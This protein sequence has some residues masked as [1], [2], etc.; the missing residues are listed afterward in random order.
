MNNMKILSVIISIC[1]CLVKSKRISE[2]CVQENGQFIR[3]QC[4]GNEEFN[5]PTNV[6]YENLTDLTIT[7]CR[8]A[9]LHFSSLPNAKI[10][11]HILIQNISGSLMFEPFV[12]SKKLETFKLRN[13]KKIPIISHDTFTS[14]S[15]IKTFVIE[16][17][18]IEQ[19]DEQFTNINIDNFILRN[20][21]IKQMIGINFSGQGKTLKIIDTIIRN[22]AGNLNF[23]FFETIEIINSTFEFEK[24]GDIP[25]EGINAKI[26]NCVFSNASVNL[27][28][29]ENIT[30]KGNCADGKSSLRL[31]SKY[32]HSVGNR[33]PTEIIYTQNRTNPILFHNINNTVCIAGN[34]KCPKSSG[35]NSCYKYHP[36]IYL[37]IVLLVILYNF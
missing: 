17:T 15:S 11:R 16:D 12:I 20:V 10:I 37:G 26:I 28:V 24:P 19:F 30:I 36:D 25:I 9:N 33:L 31:S 13:I 21:S 23:A 6:N 3:C 8:S 29:N 7:S 2:L 1:L 35:Y 32:V 4:A 34:C 14:I 18:R 22:V 5:L 27:V